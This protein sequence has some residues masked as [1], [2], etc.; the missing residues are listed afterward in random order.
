MLSFLSVKRDKLI[1]YIELNKLLWYTINDLR[2][3]N[4]DNNKKRYL[5]KKQYLWMEKIMSIEFLERV[6]KEK[7]GESDVLEFKDYYFG[8]MMSTIWSNGGKL[9][10]EIQSR[11]LIAS[12]VN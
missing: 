7:I 9:M 2:D 4:I 6:L 1:S 5:N 12:L 10:I 3:K 8:K 11:V